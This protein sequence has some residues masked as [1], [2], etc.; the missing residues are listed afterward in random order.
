M[1]SNSR[2]SSAGARAAARGGQSRRRRQEGAER[3]PRAPRTR[4]RAAAAQGAPQGLPQAP[5]APPRL[6]GPDPARAPPSSERP[7]HR[8]PR[9]PS[10][11]QRAMGPER[12]MATCAGEAGSAN[13]NARTGSRSGQWQRADG[14]G[15]ANG[16]ARWGRSGQWQRADGT[17]PA[18]GNARWGRS[19]QWQ[20][21]D[22]KPE[23][24]SRRAGTSGCG[25]RVARAFGPGLVRVPGRGA[26]A[27]SA[28][29]G[30]QTQAWP[31]QGGQ[32]PSGVSAAL[33]GPRRPRP[34][35]SKGRETEPAV[36]TDRAA[37]APGQPPG[38]RTRTWYRDH[39]R[40]RLGAPDGLWA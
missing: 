32:A 18:N 17:G 6:A 39:S 2:E 35:A 15:P 26:S 27:V 24:P 12:P 7:R 30:G 9:R 31:V 40:R 37:G 22:G 19:G 20:R 36:W 10:Q 34:L 5:A 29:R 4:R 1:T 28:A 21:A 3:E 8:P 25:E 14:T 16:N 38:L 33:P 13:S 23:R 11:W